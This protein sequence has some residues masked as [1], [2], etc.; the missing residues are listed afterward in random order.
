MDCLSNKQEESQRNYHLKLA[1]TNAEVPE[2]ESKKSRDKII[3][4]YSNYI[5]GRP[6]LIKVLW[7][8]ALLPDQIKDK[9]LGEALK[10]RIICEL[11]K[12]LDACYLNMK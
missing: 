7:P 12:D 5:Y 2:E 1:Y 4:E 3:Q 10:M 9:D 6:E 11:W 8:I